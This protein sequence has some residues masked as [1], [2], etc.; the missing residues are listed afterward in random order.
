[1]NG[2]NIFENEGLF[3][4]LTLFSVILQL[5]GY[6]ND[7]AQTSTDDL[8]EELQRQ[9]RAYLDQIIKNQ[10]LILKKLADLGADYS[11]PMG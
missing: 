11:P 7:L 5:M 2:N 10:K 9:D 6:Q 4:A 3:N 8:M 1:M